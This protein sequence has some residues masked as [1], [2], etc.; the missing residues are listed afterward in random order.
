MTTDYLSKE[1]LEDLAI[2]HRERPIGY[3]Q[4]SNALDTALHLLA[5]N[6]RLRR[7]GAKLWAWTCKDQHTESPQKEYDALELWRETWPDEDE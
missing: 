3:T 5:D 7:F 2:Q 1:E 6:E 4:V